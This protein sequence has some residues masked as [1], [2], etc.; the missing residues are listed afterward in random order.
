MANG[1]P[2]CLRH[3]K[4]P[5]SMR[6]CRRRRERGSSGP[7]PDCLP[8]GRATLYGACVET[9]TCGTPSATQPL[10][11]LPTQQVTEGCSTCGVLV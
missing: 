1:L 6:R 2:A 10:A 11:A 9:S 8:R 4:Q 3:A 7:G 5:G